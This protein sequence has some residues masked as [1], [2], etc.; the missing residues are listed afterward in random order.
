MPSADALVVVPQKEPLFCI[1]HFAHNTHIKLYLQ[2]K[3][4]R[5]EGAALAGA[6]AEIS[7]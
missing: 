6:S 7:R 5:R 3:E 2:V 4:L 1:K